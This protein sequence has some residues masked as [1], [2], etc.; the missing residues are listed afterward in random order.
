MAGGG[1]AFDAQQGHDARAVRQFP[2]QRPGVEAIQ[3][4]TLIGVHVGGVERGAAAVADPGGLVGR[5]LNPAQAPRRGQV[6]AMDVA[7]AQFGQPRLQPLAV[8]EGVLPPAHR[9]P[10]AHIDER[11]D[12]GIL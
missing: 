3:H 1:L 8:G 2:R 12:V 4:L 5:G 10:P 9:P 6:E 7:N 11:I